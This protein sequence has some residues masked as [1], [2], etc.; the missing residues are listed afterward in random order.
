MPVKPT[1]AGDRGSTFDEVKI[2]RPATGALLDAGYKTLTD[3]PANTDALRNLHGV[4]PKAL[5]LLKEARGR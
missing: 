1:P 3:L 4:G 2:G 5:R